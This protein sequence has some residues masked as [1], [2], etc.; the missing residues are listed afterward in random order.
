MRKRKGGDVAPDEE[1]EAATSCHA[2]ATNS[3]PR[4]ISFQIAEH[5]EQLQPA[6][7]H[8]TCTLEER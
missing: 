5:I 2:N 4:H 1:A 8:V 6:G 7:W 3:S